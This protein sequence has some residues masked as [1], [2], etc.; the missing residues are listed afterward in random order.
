[1]FL[2]HLLYL[3]TSVLVIALT[4][5]LTPLLLS[6]SLKSTVTLGNPSPCQPQQIRTGTHIGLN[7]FSGI[8]YGESVSQ[9]WSL[10]LLPVV[11]LMDQWKWDLPRASITA[12]RSL[13]LTSY[14]PVNVTTNGLGWS[15]LFLTWWVKQSCKHQHNEH[16]L[17]GECPSPAACRE[18]PH[19]AG[20]W[21]REALRARMCCR[22]GQ[23]HVAP[24]LLRERGPTT[25]PR[26]AVP[27]HRTCPPDTEPSESAGCCRGK[28]VA[29]TEVKTLT[30]FT[31]NHQCSV[32]HKTIWNCIKYLQWLPRK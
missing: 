15:L 28:N 2:S 22:D 5:W 10:H 32:L 23:S 16:I 18:G 14:S 21:E 7:Q 12:W 30:L 13:H 11:T 17:H 3:L 31:S 8:R 27:P 25:P 6:I 29:A 1:M 19:P 20:R 4:P 9:A 26:W 24:H